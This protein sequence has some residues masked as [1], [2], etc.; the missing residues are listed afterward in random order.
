M[1]LVPPTGADRCATN[2]IDAH[3]SGA[4]LRPIGADPRMSGRDPTRAMASVTV[5]INRAAA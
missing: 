2:K 4:Q 5:A 3:A 1:A